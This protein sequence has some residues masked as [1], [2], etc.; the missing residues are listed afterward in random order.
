VVNVEQFDKR[1]LR[2]WLESRISSLQADTWREIGG[3]PGR[4]GHWEFEDYQP[5]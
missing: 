1:R 4:F 5:E 3:R 2:T